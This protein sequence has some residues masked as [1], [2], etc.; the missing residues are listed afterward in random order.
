MNM[1][2]SLRL[3]AHAST[4]AMRTGTFPD[5]D[6]LD[7]NGLA[8]AAALRD[9]W[10]DVAGSLV[11]CSPARCAVQTA[12]AFGLHADIDDAL[13]DIDYRNWRGKR[14]HDLARDWPDELGAW[15]GDPLAS[16]H[17]GESFD[18]AMCR[19]GAWLNAL[20]HG[21]D[22]V[23]ITHA[24]IV[25]AAVAHALQ[26]D[27]GAAT[28]ID[29]APLSCTTFAASPHGWLLIADGDPRDTGA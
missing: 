12:D 24:P 20:Q 25:R 11:L 10:T 17:G 1:N 21:R 8:D 3:I 22:I 5:D 14:L 13:R 19:V 27:S 2:A 26:I 15:I 16:P 23:A 9:R 6:P 28:R 18:A 4:R 29:V 7:A